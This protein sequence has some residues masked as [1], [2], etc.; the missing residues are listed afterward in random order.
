MIVMALLA[1]MA[2][3]AVA[4]H[5]ERYDTFWADV[6]NYVPNP[7]A[8]GST[9]YPGMYPEE[10][11]EWYEYPR[12]EWWNTWFYNGP[13]MPDPWH[14]LVTIHIY[15]VLQYDPTG[16]PI[17]LALNWSTD[18]WSMLGLDRPPLPEDV[19]TQELEDRYI[20]RY[21]IDYYETDMF[22]LWYEL[23][24]VGYNPE[25]ISIDIWGQDFWITGEIWHQCVPEPAA[26]S[27]LALSGLILLRRR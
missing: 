14:K 18:E 4:E 7:Y 1:F 27:L 8:S 24:L 10:I 11:G 9:G 21:I 13:Y 26:L 20:G 2:T 17:W 15:E 3:S 5:P 22:D 6:D 12:Y 25:W 23:D 16:S 19:Y